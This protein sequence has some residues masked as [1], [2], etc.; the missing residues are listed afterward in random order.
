METFFLFPTLKREL[1]GL[2]FFWMRYKK[3]WEGD[4]KTLM[5][6]DYFARTFQ[7]LL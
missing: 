1:A 2:I 3:K 4:S 6:K 7:M 5:I